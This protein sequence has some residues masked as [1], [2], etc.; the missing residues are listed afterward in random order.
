LISGLELKEIMKI[1]KVAIIGAGQL[2]LSIAQVVAGAGTKVIVRSRR[3]D[4]RLRV[5]RINVEK[6]IEKRIMSTEQA[7][8]LLS[9]VEFTSNLI[10]SVNDVDLVIEAVV[11]DLHV[12][13]QYFQE[14]DEFSPINTI[15]AS[16]TSSL[17]IDKLA[18]V[19]KRPEKVIGMHFFN[20]VTRM[21][22]VEVAPTI[23]T[24][25]ETI[26]T[27]VDFA[28]FL[29]K[30][31]IVVK[32]SPGF[33]INRILIPMINEAAFVLVESGL[34]PETID[35]AMKLG[36]NFPMGPLALADLIGID[37]C[38]IILEEFSKLN[39]KYTPCPLFREMTIQG[40]LGKKAGKGFYTY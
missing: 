10:E 9:N 3:G 27:V 33:I 35:H 1:R 23:S 17:S 18:S 30:F 5:L 26:D 40:Y 32:D 38:L 8:M 31:P 2:G 13:K 16:N 15:L 19:T 14:I 6:A 11:E 20:P 25:K 36:A 28:I 12:K 4:E 7:Y 39:K 21:K 24:S 29:G 22:L 37:N 34:S